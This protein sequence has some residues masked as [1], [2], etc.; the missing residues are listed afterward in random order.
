MYPPL[1]LL[2]V[3]GFSGSGKTSFIEKFIHVLK[4][5]GY[6]PGYIK[7]AGGIYTLDAPGKDS[8]R[9]LAAGASFSVVFTD[10]KWAM[11]QHGPPDWRAISSQPI[12]D[13]LLLEGFKKSVH[14]KVIC[15]HPEKDVPQELA[16]KNPS[17]DRPPIWAYLTPEECQAEAINQT[18]GRPLA[19]QRD[20]IEPITEHLLAQMKQ[21]YQHI[22]PLKSAVMIGGKSTRMGEDKAWLDY[23]K[24]P[25]AIHLF[26]M[27]TQ[28]NAIEKVFFSGKPFSTPPQSIVP[29]TILSDRFLNFGPLGGILTLFECDP[30][31][32]WLVI[33]CDLVELQIETIVYLI[34]NRNPLKSATVFVNKKKRFEP[35][36]AIYEPHIGLQLKRALLEGRYSFQ[37]IFPQLSIHQL[38]IPSNLEAQLHNVNSMEERQRTLRIHKT[39]KYSPHS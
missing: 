15:L 6:F 30:K 7:H 24:G 18:L 36:V 29:E 33:A 28:M 26:E 17:A 2:A 20:A 12:T 10:K 27:L 38:R 23:G 1:P 37:Q 14:P 9:Q 25:H 4:R 34:Q 11:H 16:W 5:R 21:H 22:F 13:I 19:F 39:K 3:S 8:T 31:A 35:L 32:A